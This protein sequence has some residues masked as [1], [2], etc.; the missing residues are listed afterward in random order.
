VALAE[1]L[2]VV[3]VVAVV[4]CSPVHR[5]HRFQG[6]MRTLLLEVAAAPEGMASHLN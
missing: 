4:E 2:M 5:S 1:E 6:P 3:A